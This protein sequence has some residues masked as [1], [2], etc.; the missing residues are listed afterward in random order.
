MT[1][2]Q[3]GQCGYRLPVLFGS[4]AEMQELLRAAGWICAEINDQWYIIC[5]ACRRKVSSYDTT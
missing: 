1:R 4:L 2:A 5:P 3:C